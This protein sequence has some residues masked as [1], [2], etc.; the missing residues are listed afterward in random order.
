MTA[1]AR[2]HFTYVCTY[3]PIHAHVRTHMVDF[4]ATHQTHF[5]MASRLLLSRVAQRTA[6]PRFT[7]AAA[8]SFSSEAIVPGIGKGKTSTG[9]VSFSFILR[10]APTL[11]RPFT[12]LFLSF[13]TSFLTLYY[14]LTI[15]GGFESG[16]R[17][18]SAHGRKVSSTS[19]IAWPIVTCRKMPFTV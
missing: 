19:W 14:I 12:L 7:G 5:T 15:V 10:V 8:A 11:L 1:V 17:C 3:H 4:Y 13:S 9:L 6:I 2:A 18:H 16:S